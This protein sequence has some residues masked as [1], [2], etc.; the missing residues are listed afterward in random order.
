MWIK[1]EHIQTALSCIGSHHV[2]SGYQQNW[3]MG[4]VLYVLWPLKLTIWG[5]FVL[6][7]LHNKRKGHENA[8]WKKDDSQLCIIIIKQDIYTVQRGLSLL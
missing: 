5:L 4:K 6:I 3:W 2:W 7:E 8:S 1:K